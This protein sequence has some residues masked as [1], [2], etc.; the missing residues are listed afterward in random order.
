MCMKES[1]GSKAWNIGGLKEGTGTISGMA[2]W[3][4]PL[5]LKHTNW[6][7]DDYKGNLL[8]EIDLY[9]L[10]H[11]SENTG[12]S[13]LTEFYSCALYLFFIAKSILMSTSFINYSVILSYYGNSSE[14]DLRPVPSPDR[15][16]SKAVQPVCRRVRHLCT[17]VMW[18]TVSSGISSQ[19][20]LFL[21]SDCGLV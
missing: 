10:V 13:S 9:V 21:K 3:T 5:S 6:Q 14:F 8:V 15:H 19:V 11:S 17:F 18:G 4:Q 20:I 1:W 2:S 12:W 7:T 16:V